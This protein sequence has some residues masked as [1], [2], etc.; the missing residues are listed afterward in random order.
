ML[1][2]I[3]F[4][5]YR[6]LLN[7][8][9]TI[10][11]TGKVTQVIGLTI[12]AQGPPVEI[13]ELCYIY[14]AKGTESIQAEVVGFRN[15]KVLLMPLGDLQGIG[16]GSW[17]MATR[18]PFSIPVGKSM[19]GRVLDGLGRPIDGLGDIQ[20]DKWVSVN[21]SPPN[22]LERKRI[23][24]P[25]LLGVRSIDSL[26]TCGQGQRMGIFAGSGVGKSTLLGMIAR[27]AKA[28]INV[29]ALIGERGRE[30]REFIEKDLKEEGLKRSVVIAATSDQPAMIRVKGV[31]TAT[32]I[33]E[34]FRDQGKNT[35]LMMDS[36][37]RFAMAQREVG[38]A[39]GEPPVARGYTPSVFAQLPKILERSLDNRI[40]EKG[41]DK[42]KIQEANNKKWS[43]RS[44]FDHSTQKTNI[45]DSIDATNHW[46]QNI[47]I[48]G[49][50]AE[51]GKDGTTLATLMCL[52]AFGR[53]KMTNP[54]FTVTITARNKENFITLCSEIPC[55]NIP[56]Q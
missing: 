31:L 41:M 33:A 36:V 3:S 13:G 37:T 25:L 42:E 54:C 56:R 45:R 55:Q 19:A 46:L 30:V 9:E 10:R 50:R 16:P 2:K 26:M 1:K 18:R 4:D 6:D 14:N 43:N 11:Y 28:D 32:A 29:I 48:G 34:Y 12:E 21:N 5:Q 51:D 15:D 27:N 20:A 53:N 47:I 7:S 22:P 24:S 40:I 44:P 49:V 52:E 8:V 17:V 35:I 38:L 23:S 39:I